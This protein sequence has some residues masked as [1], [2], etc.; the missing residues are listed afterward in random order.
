M[1]KVDL[2]SSQELSM[3]IFAMDGR[4]IVQQVLGQL[5]AGSHVLAIST[6]ACSQGS[7]NLQFTA[8]KAVSQH[9]VHIIR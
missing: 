3:L 6:S 4:V 7:Y 8:G 1:V 5:A 2:A 9:Q